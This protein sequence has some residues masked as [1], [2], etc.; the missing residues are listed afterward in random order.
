[1]NIEA[2]PMTEA[3]ISTEQ[4]NQ[5][6]G[7]NHPEMASA[8]SS[9]ELT[10]GIE[11]QPVQ[12]DNLKDEQCKTGSDNEAHDEILSSVVVPQMS[13]DEDH[14]QGYS[15]DEEMVD[16]E[17][18][19]RAGDASG[20]AA[21]GRGVI[22]DK[23]PCKFYMRSGRCHF[24]EKCR[25]SHDVE[26]IAV[27]NT[28]EEKDE[29]S[30][31]PQPQVSSTACKFYLTTGQCRFGKK[32]RYSHDTEAKPPVDT[33]EMMDEELVNSPPSQDTSARAC[34][35]YARNGHC[36]FGE[37]CHNSHDAEMM[38]AD[39]EAERKNGVI[40]SASSHAAN[41]PVAACKFYVKTGTCRFGDKCHYLHA[42]EASPAADTT[43]MKTKKTKSPPRQL[44][45]APVVPC[46]FY[47]RSGHCRFGDQCLYLHD[48]EGMQGDDTAEIGDDEN[49]YPQEMNTVKN[50]HSPQGASGSVCKF[51][52]RT[53][54]CRFG[55]HCRNLHVAELR[56]VAAT[57]NENDELDYL[58]PDDGL[59][60]CRFYLRTGHCRFGEHCRYSHDAEVMLADDDIE[61][62]IEIS[63]SPSSRSRTT[64][65]S[66]RKQVDP[67]PTSNLQ[68]QGSHAVKTCRFF[69]TGK[70]MQ[71]DS[72]K[73]RH[74]SNAS[75]SED[76]SFLNGQ[77]PHGNSPERKQTS[78]RKQELGSRPTKACR[79]FKIGK[80]TNGDNCKF[81][82][83]SNSQTSAGS[84]LLNGRNS[85]VNIPDDKST[86]KQNSHATKTC[87]YFKA[88]KC[89]Q[90]DSC[91]F[92]HLSNTADGQNNQVN[93]PILSLDEMSV[94]DLE[95]LRET[96]IQ[97]LKKRYRNVEE[98]QEETTCYKFVFQPTDPDWVGPA[99]I[100]HFFIKFCYFCLNKIYF[101]LTSML[102]H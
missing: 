53:G 95:K 44:T 37:R 70:C 46:K 31:S 59:I 1:M 32:C 21:D 19:A 76:N 18:Y 57:A 49:N 42:S 8:S 29:E 75:T 78:P 80:C 64:S 52:A 86:A 54:H 88:G 72:C 48:D 65:S 91:Q 16:D 56:P 24:G 61:M 39:D 101:N 22:S 38:P 23:V 14:E 58:P 25:Y 36:H 5:N 33:A 17:S 27:G 6:T 79:F 28:A 90:G 74:L 68:K 4:L 81:R 73:F 84:N 13:G 98:T 9:G 93:S 71:G 35:F 10:L 30:R 100:A 45:R 7:S 55:E 83:T 66:A 60:A 43:Q 99:F 40:V 34:K 69:R 26:E 89:T 15:T 92:R 85:H 63:N 51:F 3:A 2:E 41:T 96:E 94:D 97:Q 62:R 82:H 20:K 47:V 12:V 87:R 11:I 50:S 77:N 67:K 102:W